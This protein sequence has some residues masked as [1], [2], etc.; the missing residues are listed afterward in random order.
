MKKMFTLAVIAVLTGTFASAQ[1]N[2]GDQLF[3]GSFSAGISNQDNNNNVNTNS[4]VGITP[5]Y[6]WMIRKNTALG[7]KGSIHFTSSKQKDNLSKSESHAIGINPGIF[8]TRYKIL[9]DKFG[10]TFTHEASAGFYRQTNKSGTTESKTK[11]RSARYNFNPGVFYRFT[12]NVMGQA[13]IGGIYALW[14]GA[15]GVNNFNAGASFLQSFN[16]GINYRIAKN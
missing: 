7:I 3:G 4:N 13:D 6:A 10:V 11:S 14:S 16:V 15:T 1:F 12:E 5:S 9:K 8:L 2:K